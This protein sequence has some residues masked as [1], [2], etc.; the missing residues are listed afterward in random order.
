M[1]GLEVKLLSPETWPD[2]EALFG[3]HKGLRGGCWCTFFRC[4]SAE[5]ERMTREEHKAFQ[6]QLVSQGRGH[7]LLVYDSG[8]P[9]AWCQFGPPTEFPHYDHGRVYPTLE[10]AADAT[11]Q[12]R[13]ACL[14]ADKHR[15]REGLATFAL[16][17]ALEKICEY[18]GGVVEAFPFDG[19][20]NVQ[21]HHTGSVE[22]F[23]REGFETIAR[24]GKHT[25]LMR[26]IVQPDPLE[27]RAPNTRF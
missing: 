26:R 5:F 13:I 14:M 25:V 3:K 16:K 15:R 24:I 22:M 20:T 7:G 4:T 23:R 27:F 19:P 9:V 1:S 10:L 8:T 11:P 2:F 12:W 21:P 6:A 17:A 18:G